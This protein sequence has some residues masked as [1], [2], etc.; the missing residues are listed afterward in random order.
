MNDTTRVVIPYESM[1][2]LAIGATDDE[3]KKHRDT[4]ELE[5][6]SASL[7]ADVRPDEPE[8]VADATAAAREAL[9]SPVDGPT[10]A[11]LLAGRASV[12][13]IID[14][15][16]RPTPSSKLL[17]AVF[18]A[19]EA[20]EVGDVRVCCANGKVFP[21][22]ESDT[23]Q[24][25]GADNLARMERNGWTFRQ[26]DPQN[27]DAYTFVGVSS[28]GTP[29]WLLNEVASADLKITIGQAQ[30]NHWGAGGGGKL[31]LPGVVSDETVESNHCAF[32]TSPQT[33]YGAYCGPM[34]SDIDEVATM[35]GLDCTMN[36]ILDTH[37]RVSDVIFGSHPEAHREAIRRF[38][39]IY[40]YDSFVPEHGQVDIAICGVFAPTDHLFFH[41]GWGCM[42]ADL[43]V[44]DGGTIIYTRP[45][46]GVSTAIGDFPG[47]AL[48][49]LMK[50]YM[51][52]TAENYQRVLRD[53]HAREIQMWAGCIW[54]PIYEV[55]TRKHL[56]LVTL[57]D[58][59]ELAAEIAIDATTSLDEAFA[60]AMARHG[61]D[62]RVAVLPFA[63][64]QLPRNA[65]RMQGADAHVFA[66]AGSG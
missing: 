22:S 20:A 23:E 25:I 35:C 56:S 33:H 16:F 14:N 37:G 44:R 51:P 43:V 10:F 15:Q 50:P 13:V 60:S 4:L 58:N 11:E 63:R 32:V 57:E 7:V 5:I 21:M 48:M 62:A 18:D 36:V 41:T 40:A 47:L 65:V 61:A 45:S 38:N 19:V 46:P 39:D 17:P 6:P 55:M 31:I 28:G 64:Y 12:A 3:S 59:L 34:R 52:A 26:N 9:A 27:P 42:S 29:V 1:D 66:Y 49:D 2:P 30:A 53:I 8:P 24:K 54:V